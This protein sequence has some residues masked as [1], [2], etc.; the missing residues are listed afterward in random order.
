M[1]VR[2]M[3]CV[4]R[5]SPAVVFDHDRRP[6]RRRDVLARFNGRTVAG[7][8]CRL[9]GD[10]TDFN[11]YAGEALAIGERA[12]LAVIDAAAASRIAIGEALTNIAAADIELQRVKISANWMAAWH[13]GRGRKA[14]RC[15]MRSQRVV[16]DAGGQRARWQRLVVDEDRMARRRRKQD[17]DCPNLTD[18]ERRGAGRRR[19]A[20]TDTAASAGHVPSSC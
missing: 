2:S 15:G 1:N 17:R 19:A 7:S 20:V 9:C 18:C 14:V 4:T 12:P 16:S 8:I 6:D 10:L 5:R 13:R 11:G 3:C